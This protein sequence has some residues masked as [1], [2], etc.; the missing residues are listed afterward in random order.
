M[1]EGAIK[2][3]IRSIIVIIIALVL[4]LFLVAIATGG[5]HRIAEILRNLTGI[6]GL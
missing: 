3:G 1:V 4:I 2:L 6:K 5:F